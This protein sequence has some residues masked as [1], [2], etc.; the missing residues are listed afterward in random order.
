MATKFMNFKNILKNDPRHV[1]KALAGLGGMFVLFIGKF[2]LVAL[3]LVPMAFVGGKIV[4]RI[5][6]REVSI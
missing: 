6:E 4:K 1:K 2:V 5:R 3:I